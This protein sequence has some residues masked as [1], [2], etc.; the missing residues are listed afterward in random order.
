MVSIREVSNKQEKDDFLLLPWDI[1]END[2]YWVPPLLMAVKQSLDTQKNPFYKHAKLKLWN[3]YRGNDCVGRIAG[4]IDDRH[5]EF[6]EEKTGFWGFF[7]CID[8]QEVA[9]SLFSQVEAWIKSEGMNTLR[10]PMS[11]STNYECGM[12][13]DAFETKP[14]IMM[15]QNPPYYPRLV[16]AAGFG[17]AKD[18]YAW[19]VSD[20][21]RSKVDSRLVEKAK[22]L[23]QASHVTYRHVDMKNFDAEVERMLEIYNDAWEK[24]WGFVPMTDEEFRAMAKDMKSIV[25]P[26]LI[27]M[28]EVRGE[29]AGF[30]VML[31]DVN[32]AMEKVRD[33]KLFPT[34]LLKLL[35]HTKVRKTVNR[36]RIPLLGVK[37]KFR[38]LG[39]GS[40][41]YL[42]YFEV[43]PKLGYPVAECSW[44]LEDNEAMNLG[45]KYMNASMYKTYRI[46]DKPV[47]MQ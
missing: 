14:F 17:K 24:N 45:L 29:P 25:V 12:Q 39:L 37:K 6:H 21:S 7:E 38:H 33:G 26:E 42:K 44:I 46:Y 41:I 13:I 20:E 16:E 19:I 22:R 34:G 40:L 15:T 10:G 1:Y 11:P 32:Q 27:L 3:A 47:A 28:V 4:I 23:E 36:G 18:L 5:N 2:P 35:W 30:G 43:G 31:P 8:D 9:N